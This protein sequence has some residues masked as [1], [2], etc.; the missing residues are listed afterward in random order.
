MCPSAFTHQV[1]SIRDHGEHFAFLDCDFRFGHVMSAELN[2]VWLYRQQAGFFGEHVQ[3][4]VGL[5]ALLDSAEGHFCTSTHVF[6][7]HIC[8]V[9][10]R[11]VDCDVVDRTE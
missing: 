3:V 4:E 1:V 6:E 7:L 5:F 8:L 10:G 11:V 2:Y 9:E